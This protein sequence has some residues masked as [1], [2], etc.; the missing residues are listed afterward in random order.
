MTDDATPGETAAIPLRGSG[1]A[2][3]DPERP[4]AWIQSDYAVEPA[5]AER[6]D[7]NVQ[8]PNPEWEW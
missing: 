2:I 8:S 1:I 4:G 3:Y 7:E 6:P 5:D